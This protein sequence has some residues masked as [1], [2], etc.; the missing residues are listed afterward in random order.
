MYRQSAEHFRC[1]TCS[2]L[3]LLTSCIYTPDGQ[4]ACRLCEAQRHIATLTARGQRYNRPRG[5]RNTRPRESVR[6]GRSFFAG[7]ATPIVVPTT[8][9][10]ASSCIASLAKSIV[11]Y[12]GGFV[13]GFTLFGSALGIL[14]LACRAVWLKRTS[15]A[16]G[17]VCSIAFLALLGVV[18]TLF[19]MG[20]A[21]G[22]SG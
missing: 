1:V 15:F 14:V 21:S 20:A 11:A 9:F 18:A 7:L 13:F 5:Q 16:L 2:E 10:L 8:L 17:M 6:S 19:V 22:I 12:E 4:Q 3:H